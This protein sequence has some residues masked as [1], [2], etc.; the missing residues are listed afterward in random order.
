MSYENRTATDPTETLDQ[1]RWEVLHSTDSLY[2]DDAE[3]ADALDHRMLAIMEVLG[4]ARVM[5]FTL[6]KDL[7][8]YLARRDGN[9]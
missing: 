4:K 1:L 3:E 2:N 9:G 6:M 5:V 7:E 8:A